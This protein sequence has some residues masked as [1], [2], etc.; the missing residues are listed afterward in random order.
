MLRDKQREYKSK[1]IAK[2]EL[3]ELK[4]KI[5]EQGFEVDFSRFLKRIPLGDSEY[6]YLQLKDQ[7]TD[8]GIFEDVNKENSASQHQL[9][10]EQAIRKLTPEKLIQGDSREYKEQLVK[11]TGGFKVN[12]SNYFY[13]MTHAKMLIKEMAF[14]LWLESQNSLAQEYHKYTPKQISAVL[15]KTE[16]KFGSFRETLSEFLNMNEEVQKK[17]IEKEKF[18]DLINFNLSA[19]WMYSY[20]SFLLNK[21]KRTQEKSAQGKHIEVSAFKSLVTYR[22]MISILLANVTLVIK[23]VDYLNEMDFVTKISKGTLLLGRKF[24]LT[25]GIVLNKELQKKVFS[26]MIS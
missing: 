25:E 22:R 7:F 15:S 4:K 6:F 1:I 9:S 13:V 23:E 11:N 24:E 14:I 26:S 5:I 19:Y 21:Q 3:V 12:E 2:S 20:F 8:D 16:K 10:F 18:I 17:V